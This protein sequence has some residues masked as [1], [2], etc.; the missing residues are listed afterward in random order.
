M[1]RQFMAPFVVAAAIAAAACNQAP[2]PAAPPAESAPAVAAAPA[3]DVEATIT[4]LERDW[5]AAIIKK[6]TAA[7]DRL[8]AEDFN[9]TSPTAHV[10]PKSSA[11][12]DLTKG[13]FVV[14]SMVLDE[15]SVNVYGDTAVAFTSQEEKS[16]YDG[17]DTSGHYHYTDVWVKK[18]GQW[19]VVASH[20]SRFDKGH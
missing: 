18:D 15:I 2:A 11:M 20:G 12:D 6:D 5:V 4:Q 7:I 13:N 8:L 10:Y 16:R 19:Q 3:E 1:T 17:K 14:D 9:G